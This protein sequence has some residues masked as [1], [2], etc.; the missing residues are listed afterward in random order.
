MKLCVDARMVSCSGIGTVL[1]NLIP[2]LSS[3]PFSTSLI[4]HPNARKEEKW[5]VD[6]AWVECDA[7]IYS[8]K[9]QV[10]LPRL[11]PKC[12]IFW[13]PHYNVPLWPIRAKKRIVTIHDAYHLAFK[14]SLGWK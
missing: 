14:T 6:H 10:A 5:I 9:E 8:I 1:K 11:I 13:S 4:A 3:L 7:P 2:P 12:D